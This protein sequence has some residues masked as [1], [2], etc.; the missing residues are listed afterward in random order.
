MSD[1]VVLTGA[2]AI[3]LLTH[4]NFPQ[5]N[6]FGAEFFDGNE[7][8]ET[9]FII[10]FTDGYIVTQKGRYSI[11]QLKSDD[12]EIIF[13]KTNTKFFSLLD[14]SIPKSLKIEADFNQ[15]LLKLDVH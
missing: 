13:K 3:N 11:N 7:E 4:I 8:G 6:V 9:D 5:E 10:A 12:R 14:A 2:K 1:E 15:N